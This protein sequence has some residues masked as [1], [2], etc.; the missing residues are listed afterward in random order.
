MLEQQYLVINAIKAALWE[1]ENTKT[2]V[3]R[4]NCSQGRTLIKSYFIQ[5]NE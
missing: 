3:R 1:L 5:N 2:E 4:I